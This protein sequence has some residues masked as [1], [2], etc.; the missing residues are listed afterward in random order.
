MG[1][2]FS[3]K[4]CDT[5]P[6]RWYVNF[7][8]SQPFI[9][10]KIKFALERNDYQTLASTHSIMVFRLNNVRLTWHSQGLIQVDYS[11]QKERNNGVVSDFIESL[12]QIIEFKDE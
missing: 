11:D 7:N 2:T 6:Q 9:L 10:P 3:V 12:I 8:L 5:N 1:L 4:E